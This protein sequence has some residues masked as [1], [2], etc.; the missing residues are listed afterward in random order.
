MSDRRIRRVVH[1]A[2]L[3]AVALAAAFVPVASGEPA[4]SVDP[5]PPLPDEPFVVR[6]AGLPEDAG[7]TNASLKACIAEAEEATFCL[8]PVPMTRNGDAWVGTTSQGFPA[9]QQ[10]GVGV[11]VRY[12]DGSHRSVPPETD[13]PLRDYVFVTVAGSSVGPRAVGA[14]ALALGAFAL[15][16]AAALARRE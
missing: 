2:L 10:V 7:V 8:L 6:L 15:V 11:L 4:L 16:A 3:A 12:A 5:D 14:P 1:R 9:G 13:E